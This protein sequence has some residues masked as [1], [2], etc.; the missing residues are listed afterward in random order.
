MAKKKTA[1]ESCRVCQEAEA[2]GYR[3]NDS[4]TMVPKETQALLR[5]WHDQGHPSF[6]GS[7]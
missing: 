2:E 6:V 5:L 3:L 1:F 7:G 4:N